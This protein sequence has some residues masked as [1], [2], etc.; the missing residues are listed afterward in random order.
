MARKFWKNFR[1]IE[2]KNLKYSGKIMETLLKKIEVIRICCWYYE[3]TLEGLSEIISAKF[4]KKLWK[5]IRNTL[6]KHLKTYFDGN[7]VKNLRKIVQKFQ[8]ILEKN[9]EE[10]WRN[11]EN[12]LGALR[13]LSKGASKLKSTLLDGN[14][15]AFRK[16]VA[17]A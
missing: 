4:G 13:N 14:L 16:S 6:H 3:K 9:C 8:I 11:F 5:N 7:Y 17:V 2:K 15:R 10:L 1:E 12:S